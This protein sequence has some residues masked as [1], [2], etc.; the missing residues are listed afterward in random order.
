M[1]F[2]Q[3]EIN[4]P[5]SILISFDI[6]NFRLPHYKCIRGRISDTARTENY[7]PPKCCIFRNVG[8]ERF[9]SLRRYFLQSSSIWS[10]KQPLLQKVDGDHRLWFLLVQ[11]VHGLS[12]TPAKLYCRTGLNC[13]TSGENCKYLKEFS[14][15][16]LTFNGRFQ[17]S[18]G[19]STFYGG[20]IAISTLKIG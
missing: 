6:S 12:F 15:T 4:F 8:H 9:E 13:T 16:D 19:F 11:L 18:V 20:V 14:N 7:R 5:W 3:K 10:V 1:C 2:E 17:K